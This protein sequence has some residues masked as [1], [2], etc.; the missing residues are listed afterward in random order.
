MAG[1]L[2]YMSPEQLRG[3]G[4]DARTDLYA[5]G[6]VLYE[7]AT[8]RRL[9]SKPSTAELTDAILNE[10][11]A[12]PRQVN[13]RISP[14]LEAVILKALD[15]DPELRYQT[16]KDLLVDLERLQ[17]RSESRSSGSGPV[18]SPLVEASAVAPGGAGWSAWRP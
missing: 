13:E 10:D 18:A 16:A 2:P 12:P 6:A 7:L 1:T 3:R 9:F 8:G 4:V 11:P 17:Q 15:K 5:A 14:G